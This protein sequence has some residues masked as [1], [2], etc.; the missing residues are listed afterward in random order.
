MPFIKRDW[1]T[2]LMSDDKYNEIIETWDN[3]FY[4]NIAS[5]NQKKKWLNLNFQKHHK[6]KLMN[7]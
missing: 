6:K 4:E 7:C 1:S 3:I 5:K 2:K